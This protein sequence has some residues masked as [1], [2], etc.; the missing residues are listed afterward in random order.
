MLDPDA[1][2]A[3][4][5]FSAATQSVSPE[6]R[7]AHAVA[8]AMELIAAKLKSATT[9]DISYELANLDEYANKIQEA[10][11]HARQA[12]DTRKAKVDPTGNGKADRPHQ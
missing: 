4:H 3:F 5:A 7:R 1:P 8:A 6:V 10:L 9:S 12:Q 11:R 2:I